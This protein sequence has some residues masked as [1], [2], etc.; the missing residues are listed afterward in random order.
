M[1]ALARGPAPQGPHAMKN[2]KVLLTTDLSQESLRP[3]AQVA[4]LAE[5]LGLEVT[6]LH[7]VEDLPTAS[8]FESVPPALALPDVQGHLAQARARLA[9]LRR[10]L[11]PELVVH[12]D[13]VAATGVAQAIA[14]YARENGFDLVAISSHGRSGFR[15]LLLGSVAEAVLRHAHVPVLVFP[16]GE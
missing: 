2:S 14:D 3:F 5:Q 7:V 6:L 11:G 4:R 1:P 13:A 12:T 16:R 9:E 8:P 15:R 10:E